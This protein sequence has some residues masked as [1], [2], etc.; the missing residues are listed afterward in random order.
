MGKDLKNTFIEAGFTNVRATASFDVFSTPEDVAF[1]HAFVGDWFFSPRVIAAATV[2]GLVTQQQFDEWRV[3]H[4][5]WKSHPGAVGGFAFGE[6][7]ATK[8]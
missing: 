4:D 3:Q 5:E 2:F 8:P 7:I 6:A 1:L